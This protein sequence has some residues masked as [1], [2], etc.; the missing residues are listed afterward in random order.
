MLFKYGF[1]D[2]TDVAFD[3]MMLNGDFLLEKP[4]DQ[5]RR[6]LSGIVKPLENTFY[7]IKTL[8][9]PS[10]VRKEDIIGILND[11]LDKR[12]S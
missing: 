5:R 7:C 10:K 9:L 2:F 3:I 1:I 11:C 6:I 12:F 8:L 4:L